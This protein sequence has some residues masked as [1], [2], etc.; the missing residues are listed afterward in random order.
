MVKKISAIFLALVLCLSVMVVPA[1]ATV[2]LGDAQV[3]FAL[4]W[5]KEYYSSGDTATLSVYMDAA[6]DLSFYTGNITIGLS[7]GI[8]MD[9]NPID[10]VKA[11]SVTADWFRAY[12]KGADTNSAWLTTASILTNLKKAN[13]D[14][15][16]ATYTTYLKYQLAKDS[17]GTHANTGVNNDGFLGSDF[18]TDEPIVTFSF[19]VGDVADGT[20]LKASITKGTYSM[21]PAAT[22]VTAMKYYKSPG[23]ATTSAN[24]A[25]TAF[26]NSQAVATATVGVEPCETHT[27]DNG[28]EK[29][30]PTCG[31]AGEMLYTCTVCKSTK[32]E[33]IEATGNH[34]AGDPVDENVVAPS[35]DTAGSKEVVVNCSV[36]GTE[37][38][39]TTETIPATQEH[40]YATKKVVAEPTCTEAG[41]YVMVCGCG[42]EDTPVTVDA[43]GH[44]FSEVDAEAVA[45]T[46]TAP[47]S[48]ALMG[49][50]RCDATEGGAEV[51]A[52]G[53]NMVAGDVVAPTC[54]TD[55]YTVYT[56]ANNCGTT[57]NR[58]VTPATDH[59]YEAVVT[60][61]T[62]TEGGYTTYTCPACGDT[63]TADEV[64]ATGH[65]YE[66][67]V[68][69]EPT[70]TRTGTMKYTCACGDSYTEEI[71]ALNH[72]NPDGTSAL[73]TIPAVEPT[74]T[75]QG[76][77][78]G[79]LCTICNAQ[80]VV[81]QGVPATGHTKDPNNAVV[82]A[83]TYTSQGYT[84]Y[85]CFCG[86]TF[87]DDY[88]P[89]LT[90]EFTF[91][92]AAPSVTT[93]RAKDTIILHPVF[94][95]EVAEGVTVEWTA[96]NENFKVVE[97][98]EDGS[99]KVQAKKVVKGTDG[100]TTFTATA[101]DAE[102]NEISSD[103]VE[104]TANAKFFQQFL[105]FFRAIFGLAKH[106]EA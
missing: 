77:T 54:T 97:V 57:E 52:L 2:E 104:L 21:T 8:S 82:T 55:G 30:A 13:T 86:D 93:L 6:D 40:N 43:L 17:A 101:V 16:N 74:C 69:K 38:S 72:T 11:N 29:V 105:G 48:E 24:L 67:S 9:D 73:E 76:Y 92:I 64:P 56:C 42:A 14:E 50:S 62:C 19:V 83:P 58:D 18:V 28:V 27:W 10:D 78:E 32:T 89:A 36:C 4:E 34:T 90:V 31:E 37:I 60:E 79:K 59:D 46:C 85:T 91:E 87:V 96:D 47:G 39:R 22:A 94:T 7:E 98:Y 33:T 3:A 61:P 70:C 81:P 1:S 51:D 26:D 99:V 53:H 100:I 44:D 65:S 12:Y 102:G 45:P 75:V 80:A 15:E 49:C 23:S 5:D 68:T 66:A 84:T 41:S 106:Y 35:C 88:V 20:E 71:P 25:A 103:T 63:Y 95:G